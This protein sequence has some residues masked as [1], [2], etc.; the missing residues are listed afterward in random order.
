MC[1]SVLGPA[2]ARDL[3]NN[4]QIIVNYWLLQM[5]FSVGVADIVA[6][7]DTI[8]SI[9]ESIDAAKKEVQKYVCEWQQGSLKKQPGC[10][11]QQVFEMQVNC[12]INRYAD[13][14]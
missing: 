2:G 5:G 8:Q 13:V 3:L 14:C 1:W 7:A 6:T 10:T 12:R 9:G 4:T 11:M